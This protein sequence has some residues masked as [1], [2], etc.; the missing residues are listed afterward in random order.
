MGSKRVLRLL[1]GHF[2]AQCLRAILEGFM[3]VN[4][5]LGQ[6]TV[7]SSNAAYPSTSVCY[8]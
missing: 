7:H 2:L 8:V 3:V 6:I 1:A 4:V 5:S